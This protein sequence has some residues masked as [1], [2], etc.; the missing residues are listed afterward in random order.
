MTKEI[1]PCYDK[2]DADKYR[3]FLLQKPRAFL[4][5]LLHNADYCFFLLPFMERNHNKK[6]HN[7]GH[8]KAQDTD[9]QDNIFSEMDVSSLSASSVV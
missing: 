9:L 2:A 5:V 4:Y 7:S 1:E 3:L 8:D 6:L